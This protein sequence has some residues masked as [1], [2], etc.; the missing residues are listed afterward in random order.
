MSVMMLAFS[1]SQTAGPII[2][3]TKTASAA[4]DFFAIID[5]PSTYISSPTI[6][7]GHD[8]TIVSEVMG[9]LNFLISNTDS[10]TEPIVT[11]LK[12]P[13][14]SAT[15]DVT[16]DS[17]NF[18]YPSRPHVKVLDNLNL[19]FE[20][21]KITAIVGA[22]GSGKSTI[23]GLLERWYDLDLEKRY[24]LPPSAIKD[25]KA[26][27]EKETDKQSP[28]EPLTPVALSGTISI[29]KKNLDDLDLKWWRSQIGLVQ[30]EPFIFNDTI[31]RN[32]EFGLVGSQWENES[33][34]TKKRLVEEA[35]KEAFADEFITGLPLGYETQVGD[36][37]IKLSGGQRQRLAIA[38]SIIKRP[39]I[40][41]LDE[42]TS[43]ID[44]RGERIVQAALDKVSEG[45]TTITIAHRL[46]TIK[47]ADKI[48]VLRKGKLIEEGTHDSLL[49]D[50]DGVYWALVNAQK[51]SMGDDDFAGESELIESSTEPL[52]RGVS[53]ASGETTAAD[54]VEV[55]KPK[56]FFGSF[57]FLLYEQME[58]WPWYLLL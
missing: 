35:C 6:V 21:G 54:V 14:V 30:Q 3:A 26:D 53:A 33:V 16:F 22:S 58:N 12:D 37:G 48:I 34:E 2:A 40:L 9:Y 20:R 36:A 49:A 13:E 46:S 23:V 56:S 31:Y 11:G 57:G 17:V 32:V 5:A 15:E 42:A 39:K 7:P 55:W 19:R 50:E 1:I 24:K 29:G 38:R 28:E 47:K 8:H 44:V 41:I 27:K 18:A 43:S 10:L 52:H 4:A 25:K 45:R 51:L